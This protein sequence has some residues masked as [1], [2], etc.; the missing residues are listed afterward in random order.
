M[1]VTLRR[2]PGAASEKAAAT[3]RLRSGERKRRIFCPQAREIQGLGLDFDNYQFM[4]NR[5]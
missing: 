2:A 4:P 3:A 5:T 1:G